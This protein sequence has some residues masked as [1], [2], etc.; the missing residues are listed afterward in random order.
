MKLYNITRWEAENK[1]REIFW[2]DKFYDDQR[3]CIEKILDWK[4]VL[5]IQ[6]TWF[7]KSLCYQFPAALF[8]GITV[9]F[10]PLIAL[11]KDQ[12]ANLNNHWISANFIN[13]DQDEDEQIRIF[14]KAVRWEIKI[15]YIAPER[16][17]NILRN[18][19][20][21]NLKISMVII[22]EAHCISVWWHDFRPSYRRIIELVRKLP[23]NFPV[24]ATTAT[25]T[26]RAE[27]DI[28]QQ[29]WWNVEVVRW[30]LLR[31]NLSL[32]VEFVNSEDEKLIRLWENILKLEW[33]WIVYVWTK[34]NAEIYSNWLNYLWISSTFYH[35]WIK[36]PEAKNEIFEWFL[37]NRWKCIVATNALGMGI[38]K[39]DIRF[40]IHTQIPQSPIHYYQEIWRAW[41]DWNDS[42]IMLL[43]DK[44]NDLELPLSF[45]NNA[46]PPIKLYYT[47]LD[48][49]KNRLSWMKDL[50]LETNLKKSVFDTIIQD[51]I[52][53]WIVL[54]NDERKYEYIW[55]N[56][57]FDTDFYDKIREQKL[58]ELDLMVRYTQVEDSSKMQFLCNYLWDS[59]D[60]KLSHSFDYNDIKLDLSNKDSWIK[61]IDDFRMSIFPD[62]WIN[63]KC[64]IIQSWVAA[65]YYWKTKVWKK[66]HY[67]KYEDWWDFD[68]YLLDIVIKAFNFKYNKYT[69]DYITFVP[70]TESWALVENFVRKL[71][72]KLWI[73]IFWWVKKIRTTEP[74]K[75]FMNSYSK[76][77]NVLN[78]FYIDDEEHLIKNKNILLFDDVYDSWNTIK[79]IA[80]LLSDNGVN[81]VAPLV[82]AKTV[83]W[84]L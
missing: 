68:D 38:D 55:Y 75:V 33:S 80:N 84:D 32:N 78:A 7:W 5:M 74:Q 42:L 35:W 36:D 3:D 50:L 54:K 52:D 11:M 15:L 82:I 16:L 73:P 56:K 45:I 47:V 77:N 48:A 26:K 51:F 25:A 58:E 2:F 28:I 79:T 69:F 24:L 66:I 20:V 8:E 53:Q 76:K 21:N 64:W 63:D 10:S 72:K 30:D 13:S 46:K 1:L 59:S 41:R 31:N 39:K 60:K 44:E 27:N 23:S 83:W 6:R 9:I 81:L 70:P 65:S 29:M 61:K 57:V 71:S 37:K 34:S 19:Y 49:V 18:E 14:S 40:I 12:V 17:D 4:R 22:D 67:S 43:F 62:L